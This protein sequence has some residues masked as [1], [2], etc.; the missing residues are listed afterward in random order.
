MVVMTGIKRDVIS[1]DAIIKINKSIGESG[2]F[3]DEGILDYVLYNVMRSRGVNRKSA[4]L[5]VGIAKNHPFVDGN[6]R[7]AYESTKVFLSLHG[8]KLKVKNERT[9]LD[10][11]FRIANGTYNIND[12]TIWIANHTK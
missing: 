1:K 5:M 9:K 6:K 11:L 12:V 7:T 2:V 8:K 10:A 4:I 3:R